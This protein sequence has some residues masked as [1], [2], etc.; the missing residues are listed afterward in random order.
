MWGVSD[1]MWVKGSWGGGDEEASA[2][3]PGLPLLVPPDRIPLTC[4]LQFV[5]YVKGIS[6]A[7]PRLL[8][9][10]L[11][12]TPFNYTL[13]LRASCAVRQGHQAEDMMEHI[14]DRFDA[15]FT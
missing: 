14:T 15:I 1:S 2:Y 9:C 5:P 11:Y 4:C 6:S 12:L 13:I 8:R 7:S 3:G 10:L